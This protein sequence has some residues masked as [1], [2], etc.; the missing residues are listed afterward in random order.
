[1]PPD[2]RVLHEIRGP[3]L[4]LAGRPKGRSLVD[5]E[6]DGNV[7]GRRRRERMKKLRRVG[8]GVLAVLMLVVVLQNTESVET[9]LLFATLSMPRA[10]L[11]LITLLIGVVIGF[12]ACTWLGRDQ[13]PHP[14]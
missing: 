11:L 10:L 14:S 9:R 4:V 8:A 5:K 6:Y 12:A 2:P 13:G 7:G 3:A 1:M